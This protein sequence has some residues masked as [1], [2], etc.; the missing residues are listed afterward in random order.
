[1]GS[2]GGNRIR[3]GCVR[4]KKRGGNGILWIRDCKQENYCFQSREDVTIVSVKFYIKE[5]KLSDLI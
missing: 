3:D 1:V 4:R 5:T 2:T